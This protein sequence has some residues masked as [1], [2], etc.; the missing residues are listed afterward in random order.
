MLETSLCPCGS[1]RSYGACCGRYHLQRQSAPSAE[2]LM[3]SRYCAYVL[4][5]ERYLLATWH[6]STRPPTLNLND[7]SQW[8]GLKVLGSETV[9]EDEVWVEFVARFKQAGRAQRLKERSRFVKEG[10]CWYYIDGVID[11]AVA[12]SPPAQKTGRNVPCPCGSGKKHKR[13]CG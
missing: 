8:L 2:L 3:R 7:E 9:A 10:G 4:R 12:G 1:A 6:A 11:E 13:C 5:N